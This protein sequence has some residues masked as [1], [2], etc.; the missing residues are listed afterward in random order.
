M[1]SEEADI[2]YLQTIVSNGDA[3]GAMIAVFPLV[4]LSYILNLLNKPIGE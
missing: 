1:R 3:P 2:F 4:L